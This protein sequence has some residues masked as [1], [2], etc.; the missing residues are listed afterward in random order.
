MRWC[1]TGITGWPASTPCRSRTRTS[2]PAIRTSAASPRSSPAMA[3]R[4]SRG[5]TKVRC[6]SRERKASPAAAALHRKRDALFLGHL[7]V[8]GCAGLRLR[9]GGERNDDLAD[10]LVVRQALLLHLGAP[11]IRGGDIEHERIRLEHC[12]VVFLRRLL[13]DIAAAHVAFERSKITHQRRAVAAAAAG[14]Q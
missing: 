4:R 7:L 1:T 11:R 12:A 5:W 6:G 2:A 8:L 14:A 10:R 3:F 9:H 13:G